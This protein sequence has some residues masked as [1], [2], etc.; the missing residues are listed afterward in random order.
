MYSQFMM[1]GQKIRKTLSYNV[2]VTISDSKR[3]KEGVQNTSTP[4]LRNKL[5]L[6]REAA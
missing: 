1:H 5:I 6:Y 2:K 4:G 3:I